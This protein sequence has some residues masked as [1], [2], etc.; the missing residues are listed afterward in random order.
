MRSA[1][2]SVAAVGERTVDVRA[3][4]PVAERARDRAQG[5]DDVL[6]D[7]VAQH[8]RDGELVVGLGVRVEVL[9]HA[10]QQVERA[11][12]GAG[13]A[14]EDADEPEVVEVLV[15]HDDPLEV[16]DPAPV[17]RELLLELVERAAGVRP[18]VDERERLVVDQV[19]V[20]VA[21]GERRRD[22]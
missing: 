16:L 21:D 9:H 5:A 1:N 22:R 14:G 13:A 6:R 8:Q 19:A 11:D 10:G 12:L 2:G 20:D 4:A 15:G 17:R 3:A 7:P 18:A